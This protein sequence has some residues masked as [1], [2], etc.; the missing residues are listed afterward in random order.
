MKRVENLLYT[1]QIGF[2]KNIYVDNVRKKEIV[3]ERIGE[4]IIKHTLVHQCCVMTANV[5]FATALVS[6]NFHNHNHHAA[7]TITMRSYEINKKNLLWKNMKKT[8]QY[9]TLTYVIIDVA[10]KPIDFVITIC[11]GR[12]L[13]PQTLPPT[14][15]SR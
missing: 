12:G 10:T 11:Q 4:R 6:T 7:N 1:N 9:V 2:V 8:I 15:P 13:L 5:L 3:L 14:L